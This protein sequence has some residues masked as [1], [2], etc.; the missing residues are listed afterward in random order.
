MRYIKLS[1]LS[2]NEHGQ[3][4][5]LHKATR[6]VRAL[7]PF[8]LRGLQTWLISKSSP[9]RLSQF[10]SE[11]RCLQ[12][13]YAAM[14]STPNMMKTTS[15]L[16]ID[17]CAY[18]SGRW[19]RQ[20]KVERDSRY[21]K[22]NFEALCQRIID[23]CP[24]ADTIVTCQKIE[25]GFNR[26]F[27]FTLDNAKQIVA[28]LPFPLAGPTK[29]TTASEVA[30]VHYLQARTSIPIPTILDWHDD[31]AHEDNLIGSEYIIMEHASG[32]PLREKWQ[33]MTGDQQ[34]RCIDAIY[35]MIKEAVDLEFPAFGSI[36]FN[37]NVDSRYR[38]FLDED[39]CIGP[40]CSSR[41]W[42][43]NPGEHRYYHRAKPNH[44]PWTRIEEY[45][46]GLIDAGISRVPPA[47]TEVGK[48]PLY[49]GSVQNHLRLLED[50]QIV[51]RQITTDS[52][53]KTTSS[54]LLFHPDLHMRNIFISEDEPSLIS[55]IIDWQAA[56][57]EPAFWYSDEVPDFA[58]EN[59]ICAKTF[60]LSSQFLTPKLS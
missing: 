39:F 9:H 8:T 45:C 60:E 15:G 11:R 7:H 41:Y 20:D 47:D 44:G 22:F 51:L 18:T 37:N 57:I 13:N 36:Y 6:V 32:V 17:P 35:R 38:K 21:I 54:P 3:T 5:M 4:M 16:M 58:R 26:V 31:A 33:E 30:T 10:Y 19:L 59:D 55:S 56:N 1:R 23:L 14:F 52:Q 53:I 12:H 24:G 27:I 40:H 50:A 25:G 28:K 46:D 34:V 48:K 42:D 49:H 43:C 2:R 29:L